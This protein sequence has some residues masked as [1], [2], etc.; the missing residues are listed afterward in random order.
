[1]L[2]LQC[3]TPYLETVLSGDFL[4]FRPDDLN[5]YTS[6]YYSFEFLTSFA[7]FA[8]KWVGGSLL[9]LWETTDT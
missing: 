4:K 6:L 8:S 7:H 9:E 3:S 1:M 2:F 5:K